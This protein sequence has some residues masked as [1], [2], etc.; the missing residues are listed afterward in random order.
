MFES[1]TA[2]W[3]FAVTQTDL[4]CWK[5]G[6]RGIIITMGDEQINPYIPEEQYRNVTGVKCDKINTDDLYK[7]IKGKYDVYHLIVNHFGDTDRAR[8]YTDTVYD[9]WKQVISDSKVSIVKVDEIKDKI[10]EIITKSIVSQKDEV[11]H[12]GFGEITW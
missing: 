10:V 3:K 1:Y 11:S 9:S 7:E 2:A 4:D 12:I 8:V 5:R 6:K